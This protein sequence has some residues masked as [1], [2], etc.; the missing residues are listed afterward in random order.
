MHFNIYIILSNN[1]TPF[2]AI[3]QSVIDTQKEIINNS[4]K[5][6]RYYYDIKKTLCNSHILYFE[7]QLIHCKSNSSSLKSNIKQKKYDVPIGICMQPCHS[8]EGNSQ[9]VSR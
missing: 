1:Y 2:H 8:N 7:I 3:M 4:L 9:I 5:P 6:P